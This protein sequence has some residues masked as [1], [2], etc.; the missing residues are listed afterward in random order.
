MSSKNMQKCSRSN[1]KARNWMKENGFSDTH[2]FGHTRWS[3]DLHFQGLEFDGIASLGTT[4]VLF[5]VKS[6]CR[7]PKKT[8]AKYQTV[9]KLFG[10][11]C[12][13]IN[14]VDR[15]PLEINNEPQVK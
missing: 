13:W 6:N 9:S 12:L 14:A 4:L 8:L 2:F 1:V 10:I 5:Q 3:K 15:K 7:C 11:S